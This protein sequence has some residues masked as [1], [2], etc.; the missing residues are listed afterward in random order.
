MAFPYFVPGVINTDPITAIPIGNYY[1]SPAYISSEIEISIYKDKDRLPTTGYYYP[2]SMFYAVDPLVYSYPVYSNVSYQDVNSDKE[3]HKKV[4]KRY[5]SELY[6][7][8]IPESYPKILNFVRLTAKDI[9]L[10]KS[11]NEAKSNSTKE[12]DFGEKINYLADYIF[13]KKDVYNSLW[14][15]VEK[16]NIKWWDLKY[17]E[18]DIENLL[19]KAV[20]DKI[21]EMILD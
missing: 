14:N 11:A 17:Y 9:E 15:Y 10:V 16:R 1:S 4:S 6:N 12:E 21:R 3:L 2:T 18:D 13:T 7:R 20:E 5:F 8:Y 19:V